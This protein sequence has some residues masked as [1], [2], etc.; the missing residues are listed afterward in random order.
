VCIRNDGRE[1]SGLSTSGCVI[2]G[3]PQIPGN[4]LNVV[5]LPTT[6]YR[7]SCRDV[8]RVRMWTNIGPLGRLSRKGSSQDVGGSRLRLSSSDGQR[9]PFLTSSLF[10]IARV[11]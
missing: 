11:G 3:H 7:M 8:L 1:F 9:C 6:E 4:L 10:V 5:T 2:N